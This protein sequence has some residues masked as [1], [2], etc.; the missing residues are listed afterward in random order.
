MDSGDRGRL[1][2]RA[3]QRAVRVR[4]STPLDFATILRPYTVSQ[5]FRAFEC[6]EPRFS[7]TTRR[8]WL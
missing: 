4:Q 1:G 6:T 3:R 5:H 2:P 7:S 8:E